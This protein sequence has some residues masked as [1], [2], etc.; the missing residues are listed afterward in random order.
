MNDAWI[1]KVLFAVQLM[2]FLLPQAVRAQTPSNL[3]AWIGYELYL[4]FKEKGRWGLLLEGYAK[5]NKFVSQLQGAFYRIGASYYTKGG[6]RFG[7]GYAYQWNIPYDEV[8][9][10][11]ANP[12]YRVYEQ[13]I[14]RIPRRNGDV[15]WTQRF[16]MEQRWL[17]RKDGPNYDEDGFNH[18]KFENTLRYQF[19]YQ[20]WFKPRW[21]WTAYDELHI[22]TTAMIDNENFIDQN[23]V[24]LGGMYSLDKKREIRLELGYMNQSFFESVDTRSGRSRVNHTIRIT[25]TADYPMKHSRVE[26][27]KN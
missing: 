12:D 17:G 24:Y 25:I 20:R 14:W 5:G 10:S 4:P 13:F 2:I 9:L 22:R 19:R 26:S 27:E 21:G 8:S 1:Y 16:R 23:R 11:Y 18:Y 6:N 15:V 3:A 7:V